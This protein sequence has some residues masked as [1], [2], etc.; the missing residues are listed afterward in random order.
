MA[1]YMFNSIETVSRERIHS[2]NEI[3]TFLHLGNYVGTYM[4]E[5]LGKDIEQHLINNVKSK[6]PPPNITLSVELQTS[7]TYI[8]TFLGQC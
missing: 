8:A 5:D 6:R 4:D 2:P 1:K 7:Q 3:L